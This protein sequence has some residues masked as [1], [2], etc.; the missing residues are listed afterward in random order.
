M[1]E[2]LERLAARPEPYSLMSIKDLWTRPHIARQMLAYHLDQDTCLASRPIVVIE[3]VVDWLDQELHL[4]GKR[5]CDLGCGPGLY[6][7][8]MAE[9]GA[10][11]TGVDFSSTAIAHA[12]SQAS[13]TKT[14]IEYRVADY[15]HDELPGGFDVVT[16]IYYDFCALSPTDRCTL[17]RRM[18]L[19]LNPGGSL[20]LDVVADNAFQETGEQLAI[21]ERLMNGFWSESDYVG[22]HRTWV[23]PEQKLSLDHYAI[24]EPSDY[25]EILNW[26]QYFSSTQLAKE[27]EEAGFAIRTLTGSL[28]G[29]ALTDASNEIGVIADKCHGGE[30]G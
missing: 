16:L 25:W 23:Y 4:A 20:V 5:I 9:R 26:M 24:V 17:L 3:E 30:R 21:E 7:Q 14:R 13:T 28:T 12:E 11:V 27:L 22:V 15:L 19:M 8:R 1:Y 29:E 18:H 10:N 2:L 6:A